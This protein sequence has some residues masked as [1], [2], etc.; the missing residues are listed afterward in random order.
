MR[1]WAIAPGGGSQISPSGGGLKFSA[2]VI[3]V[4]NCKGLNQAASSSSSV[5]ISTYKQI[6]LTI[7]LLTLNI[8]SV[9]TFPV[10]TVAKQPSIIR[11]AGYGQYCE[12]MYSTLEVVRPTS[13]ATSLATFSSRDSP[14]KK[15][16]K[17]LSKVLNTIIGSIYTG[18]N[19]SCQAR[20]HPRWMSWLPDQQ[21]FR[22][23]LIFHKGNSNWSCV[24]ILRSV[25]A[26]AHFMAV[27][28]FGLHWVAAFWTKVPPSTPGKECSALK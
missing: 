16:G 25:A 26:G 14:N 2:L 12:A 8:I 13:S 20:K 1:S 10:K 4:F 27:P 21:H 11:P 5:S 6:N 15:I 7:K 9:L 24:R 18:I 17:L 28:S 23:L 19:K 22:M 3:A